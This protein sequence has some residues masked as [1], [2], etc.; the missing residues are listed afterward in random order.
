M[1]QSLLVVNTIYSNH[2]PTFNLAIQ[3]P[4]QSPS[5][6]PSTPLPATIYSHSQP[7]SHPAKPRNSPHPLL[8]QASQATSL[9]NSIH[10]SHHHNPPHVPHSIGVNTVWNS[11]ITISKH[12]PIPQILLIDDIKRINRRGRC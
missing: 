10:E 9:L 5:H 8:P 6:S 4:S 7:K 1:F 12:P 2:A 3:N 11:I